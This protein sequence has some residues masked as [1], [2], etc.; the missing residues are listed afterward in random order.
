VRER[1]GERKKEKWTIKRVGGKREGEKGRERDNKI[2]KVIK[3]KL[4]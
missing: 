3:T 1:G 4:G 2:P